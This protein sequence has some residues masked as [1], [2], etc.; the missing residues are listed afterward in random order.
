VFIVASA[1][2]IAILTNAMRVSGTGILAHYY[3]TR[4]AEGFF[5]SFSGWAVYLVAFALLLAVTWLFDRMT[6]GFTKSGAKPEAAPVSRTA[7]VS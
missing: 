7:E 5:H 3:G 2:P 4:V 1:I 6:R